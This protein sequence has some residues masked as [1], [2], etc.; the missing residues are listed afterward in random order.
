MATTVQ[1]RKS[2]AISATGAGTHDIVAAS[3][4]K[5]IVIQKM[6]LTSDTE[7]AITV[8]DSGGTIIAGPIPVGELGGWLWPADGEEWGHTTAGTALQITLSVAA[9]VGGYV[10]YYEE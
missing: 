9:T 10:G 5:K 7:C 2:A 6:F 3:A 4:G 8:R 1:G